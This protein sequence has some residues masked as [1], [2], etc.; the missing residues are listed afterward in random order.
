M[1]SSRPL[2]PNFERVKLATQASVIA[3]IIF[4]V[5]DFLAGFS[6]EDNHLTKMDLALPLGKQGM[7]WLSPSVT[8][9]GKSSYI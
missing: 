9:T 5:D 4:G 3:A 1:V 8:K 7:A 6:F 2:F